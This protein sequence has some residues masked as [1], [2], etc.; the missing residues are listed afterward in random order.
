MIET[1]RSPSSR[2]SCSPTTDGAVRRADPHLH[3]GVT[4][5]DNGIVADHHA[6]RQFQGDAW[7]DYETRIVGIAATAGR[8]GGRR[9][10][11]RAWS[12]PRCRCSPAARTSPFAALPPHVQR[13]RRRPAADRGPRRRRRAAL[14]HGWLT[15]TRAPSAARR[16]LT[17]GTT[18]QLLADDRTVVTTRQVLISIAPANDAPDLVTPFGDLNAHE[19]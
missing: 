10:Q 13:C 1:S 16:R 8:G 19:D 4:V 6:G 15:A 3:A 14:L 12:S 11:R 7:F 9:S 5:V 18:R 17:N 2:P